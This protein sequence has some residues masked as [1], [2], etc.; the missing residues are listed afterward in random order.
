MATLALAADTACATATDAAT[1]C[2]GNCRTLYD[3]VINNCDDAVSECI[4]SHING[5][6]AFK[7]IG[8]L[9]TNVV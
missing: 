6:L 1:V 3:N 5:R 7:Y 4:A 2:M 8:V 9:A